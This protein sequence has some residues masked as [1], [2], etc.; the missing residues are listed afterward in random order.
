MDL[1]DRYIQAVR[2]WLPRGQQDDIAAE[3]SEDIRSEVEEHEGQLGRKLNDSEMEAILRQRGRPLF[4]ANRYRPQQY[5]IGPVLFPVYRFVLM[6]AALC[7]LLPSI[8]AWIGAEAFNRSAR[9]PVGALIGHAWGTLWLTTLTVFGAVTLVFALFER[10]TPNF[11]EDWNPSKLPA[12]R[13]ARDP[14]RIPRVNS[15]FQF[16]ANLGFLAW[17]ATDMW[18]TTIFDRDGVRIVL[19]PVWKFF[20][21]TFLVLAFANVI[22]AAANLVRPYWTW[23]RASLQLA[24]TV[25]GAAAFCW[26]CKAHVLAQ[27]ALPNLSPSRAAEIVN[28]INLDLAHSFPF[29]VMASVLIIA[30]SDVGRLIRLR[31]SHWRAVPGL[32]V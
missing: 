13:A 9:S 7:Y 6:I 17:W 26:L 22:L 31:A 27:I 32:A 11:R 23:L 21:W 28:A 12:V 14:Y 4:V 20:L 3:L 5:L 16:A 10:F 15:T 18:S 2:F 25:A 30:L 29:A 24:L 1:L 19:A 8:L